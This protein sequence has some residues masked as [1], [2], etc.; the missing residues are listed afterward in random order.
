MKLLLT[1]LLVLAAAAGTDAL[2]ATVGPAPAALA[3]REPGPTPIPADGFFTTTIVSTNSNGKTVVEYPTTVPL[4]PADKTFVYTEYDYLPSNVKSPRERADVLLWA[5]V[6]SLIAAIVLLFCAGLPLVVCYRRR[7]RAEMAGRTP[8]PLPW[9][10]AK[11]TPAPAPP[12]PSS[13]ASSSTSSRKLLVGAVAAASALPKAAAAPVRRAL[14]TTVMTVY[15]TT[16]DAWRDN[17][18][19]AVGMASTTLR[20]PDTTVTVFPE[21]TQAS[22]LEGMRTL[23]LYQGLI[24]MFWALPFVVVIPFLL[25]RRY[26]QK[27]R[28]TKLTPQYYFF[29]VRRWRKLQRAQQGV[30]MDRLRVEPGK[31][32]DGE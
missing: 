19:T 13:P 24:G 9:H 32:V 26:M 29:K 12:R 22:Y 5:V 28:Q 6:A 30:Q 14:V 7:V 20:V 4:P 21:T 1:A 16:T 10:R 23:H 8:E 17:V 18:P 15:S 25:V 3:P 27:E 31:K 2:P 11:P